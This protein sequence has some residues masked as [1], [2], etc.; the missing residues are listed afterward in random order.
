MTTAKDFLLDKEG[1]L[2]LNWEYPT[3]ANVPVLILHIFVSILVI[4]L[5]LWIGVHF[6]KLLPW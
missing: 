6:V 4:I 5:L 3:I 1:Y 2:G